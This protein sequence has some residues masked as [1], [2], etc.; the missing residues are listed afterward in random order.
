MGATTVSAIREAA[1]VVGTYTGTDFMS[2]AVID[3]VG[4]GFSK[5]AKNA[6]ADLE[7][8][9]AYEFYY[10]AQGK[11][12]MAVEYDDAAATNNYQY[13]YVNYAES[14][15]AAGGILNG[16]DAKVVLTAVY[17]NGGSALLNYAVK[18]KAA[19]DEYYI[20]MPD[21]TNKVVDNSGMIAA[22]WYAYTTNENGDVTLKDLNS[23]YAQEEASLV[24]NTNK[25]AVSIGGTTYSANSKTVLTLVDVYGNTVS[26]TGI[27]NFPAINAAYPT[28]VTHA[29]GSALAKTIT[30]YS[31]APLTT[32][33][34]YGYCVMLWS[35]D[36]NGYTYFFYVDGAPVFIT[37]ENTLATSDFD[38]GTGYVY[39][40]TSTSGVYEAT[41]I[42][43]T[44]ELNK[45][46]DLNTFVYNYVENAIID[47]VD[48]NY[49][50]TLA[51][52]AE[53]YADSQY[54]IWYQTWSQ[55]IPGLEQGQLSSMLYYYDADTI[56]YD[57]VNGGIVTELT[58]GAAFLAKVDTT[59][60]TWAG[61]N[62]CEIIWI[63]G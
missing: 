27:A 11:I 2:Q 37:L 14:Q 43:V 15:A 58:E 26:Y 8:N 13:L 9:T 22:G 35:T 41:K 47:V 20:T 51:V 61:E 19:T 36:A 48:D 29:N 25:A 23:T 46:F 4:I 18:Y 1:P 45:N 62:Y 42:T 49:F 32:A 38:Q 54:A 56:I 24:A 16:K 55:F 40:L 21:G 50:T 28:L 52:S 12:L 63:V 44:N 34:T 5:Y 17:P 6:I 59:T 30:A 57:C 10:D 60:T 7:L 33:A 53:D 39:E 31:A 3:G